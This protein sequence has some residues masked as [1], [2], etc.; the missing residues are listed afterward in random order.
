[1]SLASLYR[2]ITSVD[3]HLDLLSSH[4]IVLKKQIT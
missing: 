2:E 3:E 4:W 1:M